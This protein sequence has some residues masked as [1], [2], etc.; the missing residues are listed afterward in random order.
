MA[1]VS[2]PSKKPAPKAK[3]SARPV[4]SKKPA[5]KPV[6]KPPARPE[7]P[8]ATVGGKDKP[9]PK[10]ITI[11]APKQL[12]KPKPK[13]VIEMPSLGAPLMGPGSKKWK[14][15]IP[16]GPNAPSSH[17]FAHGMK[18]GAEK[19]KSKL[20][21]REI[22]RFRQILLKKRQDLVGDVS[23]MEGDALTG[24]SG[25]LSHMPQHIA[26]QGSEAYEQSLALDLAS[27]DRNLI[28][29]IDDALKR[30]DAG[31]FGICELTGKPISKERLEEL[32]WTRFSIE[33][34][35]ESERRSYIS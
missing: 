27:V 20:D 21:K 9:K 26:E 3:A 2:K 15:L 4:P 11:V 16:S 32:P 29:E 22:E 7:P 34:A 33:A 17:G 18:P 1:K 13:K 31:T 5:A 24:N 6:V 12:K 19:A 14:P 8:K 28:R 23:R 10:G 25:S 30:I 35:R